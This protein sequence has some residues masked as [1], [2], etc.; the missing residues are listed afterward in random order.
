MRIKHWLVGALALWSCD[1]Y[2]T[3]SKDNDR[4]CNLNPGICGVDEVCS[5]ITARCEPRS[6]ASEDLAMPSDVDMA[7]PADLLMPP[8][9]VGFMFLAGAPLGVTAMTISGLLV[10]D[11][12]T[13][14]YPDIIFT[15]AMDDKIVVVRNM[16]GAGFDLGT[17]RAAGDGPTAPRLANV[18]GDAFP[19]VVNVNTNG[20]N[21]SW[22]DG[23]GNGNLLSKNDVLSMG[24]GPVDLVVGNVFGDTRPAMI[25][26]NAGSNNFSVLRNQGSLAFYGT[27]A[28]NN[29]PYTASLGQFDRTA[30]DGLDVALANRNNNTVTV[31]NNGGLLGLGLYSILNSYTIN[32]GAA[33]FS[34]TAH[35]FD[36][37]G[38]TDIATVVP[39]QSRVRV[40]MTN[41]QPGCK[42][43]VLLTTESSPAYG[44][45]ADFNGDA[46]MDLAVSNS[47][48]KSVSIFLNNAGLF[49]MP[50]NVSTGATT[51]Y[52]IAAGD[53][54]KDGKTDIVIA[55]Q[56]SSIVV[57]R[58]TS[59]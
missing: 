45:V 39:S 49:S 4:N 18:N 36:G 14:T 6:G 25:V 2:S 53:F 9:P 29:N 13:D 58:N 31:L 11:L 20:N 32:A 47:V 52:W 38:N 51:P 27:Y 33:V 56:L 54:D 57:L 35:D 41:G 21:L 23:D 17:P 10:T 12:N 46:K 16:S 59:S 8:P 42:T 28:A 1:I 26:A 37:D 43:T 15:D 22:Y 30:G 19:D 55:D 50:L 24:V 40:C 44:V 48:T 7:P 3:F 34:A 5:S